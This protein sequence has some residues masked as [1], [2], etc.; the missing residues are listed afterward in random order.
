MVS[1]HGEHLTSAPWY[2]V[3]G[4]IAFVVLGVSSGSE[5]PCSM[6]WQRANWDLGGRFLGGRYYV[7]DRDHRDDIGNV[8]RRMEGLQ[9]ADQFPSPSSGQA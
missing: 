5:T 2:A 7:A 1:L 6:D 9:T 3:L 4:A 8:D